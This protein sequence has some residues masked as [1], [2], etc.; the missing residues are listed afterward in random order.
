ML[1]VT[2]AAS[3]GTSETHAAAWSRSR[4][5]NADGRG[6]E[7]DRPEGVDERLEEQ[8]AFGRVAAATQHA[9]AGARGQVGDGVEEPGLADAGLALDQQQAGLVR[10]GEPGPGPLDLRQL[11]L[12][13]HQE[14]TLDVVAGRRLGRERGLPEHGEVQVSGLAVGSRAEVLAQAC[15]QVVVRR[16]CSSRP[17]VGHERAHQGAD[18]LLVVRVRRHAHGSHPGPLGGLEGGQ[19]LG[20]QVAGAA[21]Q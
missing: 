4:A 15:G 1:G 11:G 16:E 5:V 13:A 10:R 21:T 18:G 6:V 14:R 9:A 7:Q 19:C 3:S 20:E 2:T 8:R 17:A 12:A